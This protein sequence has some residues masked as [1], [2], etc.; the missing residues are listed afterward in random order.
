MRVPATVAAVSCLCPL[1]V[2]LCVVSRS[3]YGT[4]VSLSPHSN[5]KPSLYPHFWSQS[6][7]ETTPPPSTSPKIRMPPPKAIQLSSSGQNFWNKSQSKPK[8]DTMLYPADK[9]R[10]ST[11]FP[12]T[13]AQATS[14]SNT[15][16]LHLAPKQRSWQALAYKSNS[17]QVARNTSTNGSPSSRLKPNANQKLWAGLLPKPIMNAKSHLKISNPN[18]RDSL[19]SQKNQTKLP[20]M[21]KYS[22]YRPKRGWIR[23]Q[24]YVLEEHIGPEPQYVGKVR[25]FY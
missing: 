23:N 5:P 10:S 9:H 16:G 11:T 20:D 19:R 1:L 3:C 12:S 6:L 21:D 8:L 25:C 17:N 13:N 2:F 18:S 24:F 7:P 15:T 4:R 14:R 22:H